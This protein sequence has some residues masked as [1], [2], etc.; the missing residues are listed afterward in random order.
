MKELFKQLLRIWHQTKSTQ[1]LIAIALFL[2]L[3]IFFSFQLFNSSR[4]SDVLLYANLTPV[5]EEEVKGFLDG[6]AI[7]YSD[8]GGICVP[9]DQAERVRFEL[10][11]LGMGEQKKGKGFE[12]F[13]TNTWIKGEKELQVLEMRALKGQLEKDLT[14]F[15][16][17]KSASVILDIAPARSFGNQQY[18]TKA[19]VIVTLMQG[20]RL[21]N[22]Q[23]KAITHHLAGAVRGLEPSMIAISD[24]KGRLYQAQGEQEV[25]IE[26]Q[27]RDHVEKLCLK[28]FGSENYYAN[29][30]LLD[31]KILVSVMINKNLPQLPQA[32]EVARQLVN[33]GRG[34]K[35]TIE[36][37]ID[38][39][40][41]EKKRSMWVETQKKANKF[42]IV[43]FVIF[44]I[45]V[46]STPIMIYLFRR[47]KR[48]NE[49]QL[50]SM[51]TRI[52]INK[53]ANAIKDEDPETV[54]L[55]L[56]YLEPS[57]AEK[58][59]DAFPRTF[60]EEVLIY[61]ESET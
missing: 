24:T 18:K 19:S 38:F 8:R 41:F 35:V 26:E 55:M 3:I 48:S 37:L 10:S 39:V 56:S 32:D 29:V 15:E 59:L 45:F 43:F 13:D 46:I 2:M 27:I 7:P 57:R 51:M 54:A 12:L 44:S 53:L 22:S 23:L 4:Q 52:D 61:L 25:I 6:F 36:P 5:E 49:D 9:A 17:I 31:E 58:I 34:F 20:A 14:A 1:K 42:P 21:S 60:Q 40:P 50:I 16:D 11:S 28:I 47:K 33:I 30:Q